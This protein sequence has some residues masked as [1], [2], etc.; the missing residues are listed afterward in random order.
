METVDLKAPSG[1]FRVVGVHGFGNELT[2]EDD[3]ADMET[4]LRTAREHNESSAA[5]E[6]DYYLRVYDDCGL[7]LPVTP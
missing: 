5:A 6:N 2:H 7:S 4:A 3:F 1:M